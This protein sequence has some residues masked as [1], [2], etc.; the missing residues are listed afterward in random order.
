MNN[1]KFIQEHFTQLHCPYCNLSFSQESINLLKEENDYWVVKVNC[2]E[3][4]QSAGIAIV[5]IEYETEIAESLP[6]V[7]NQ[8]NELTPADVRRL[9]EQPPITSDDV[10]SA[11]NFIQ[12]LGSDWMKF[13]R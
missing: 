4:N 8:Q 5:G 13:L 11:H 10:I 9:R 2:T 12:N 3:C 1:F 6:F 7:D